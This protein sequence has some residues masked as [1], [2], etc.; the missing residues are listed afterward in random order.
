MIEFL[1]IILDLFNLKIKQLQ[2]NGFGKKLNRFS[3]KGYLNNI[4][5]SLLLI[6]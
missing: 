3:F 6:K 5:D 2:S 4:S 1:K